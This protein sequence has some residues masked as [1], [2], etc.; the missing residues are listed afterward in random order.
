ME[1]FICQG[2][3]PTNWLATF[4]VG[5]IFHV[6]E[7]YPEHFHW[8]HLDVDRTAEIGEHPERFPL[9]TK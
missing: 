4:W 9:K 3:F 8:P 5:K 6:E 1:K 7:P 2:F